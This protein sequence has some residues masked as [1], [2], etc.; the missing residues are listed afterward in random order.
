MTQPRARLGGAWRRGLL[1]A[2]MTASLAGPATLALADA[3][4][5]DQPRGD[6]RSAATGCQPA[7][8]AV[9]PP[10]QAR[11][12]G[13]QRYARYDESDLQRARRAVGALQRAEPGLTRLF[14]SA[15]GYAVFAE[16]GTVGGTDGVGVLFEDGQAAGRATLPPS[17]ASLRPDGQPYALVVFLGTRQAVA[18]F[19]QGGLASAARARAVAIVAGVTAKLRYVEGVSV[20]TLGRE[21]GLAGP[22]EVRQAFAYLPYHREITARAP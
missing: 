5:T 20:V 7:E 14:E 10:R 6:A 22:G 9:A 16:V 4:V 13:R 12:V 11:D 3:A 15:A 21:A 2:M 1:G 18:G 8:R 19:K 17:P